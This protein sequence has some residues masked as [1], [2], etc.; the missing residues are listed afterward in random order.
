MLKVIELFSG[1]GAQRKALVN[2]GVPHEV[3]GI[4][5]IDKFAIKSYTALYGQTFNYGDISKIEKLDYCDLLTYSFPCTDLSVS[6]KLKG[7][8]D[9]QGNQTRSGLLLEVQRLLDVARG[10]NEL[11]K[12]L[13]LENVKNLVGKRFMTDFQRWLHYLDGVGYNSYWKVLNAKDFGI[14]QNRERVFVVSI[15]K[16]VDDGKFE[17]PESYDNGLRLQDFL[18]INVEE[19]YYLRQELQEKFKEQ[20]INKQFSSPTSVGGGRVDNSLQ[21]V[22]TLRGCGLPYNKMHEQS[23][24]VY[25]TDGYAPTIPTCAGG[26]IEPKIIEPFAVASRGRDPNNP[27]DRTS[28][29]PN[30]EQRFEP[31]TRGVSNTLTTV[32]K[33]SYVCQPFPRIRKLTPREMWRLMGFSDE[34]YNKAKA[35]NSETQLKKQAGNS[36]VVSVLVAIFKNL[37]KI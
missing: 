30:L 4:S 16:D 19:R 7:L 6:G 24:R 31:N 14:A 29:N 22:G 37:L 20:V 35:V 10:Y 13:L 17:F 12:F 33:D 28:G 3:V 23:C 25:S 36:I 18:E 9:E 1:I 34:D 32:D 2:L 26:N 8:I 11:P 5:E 21:Q 15:R 27:S